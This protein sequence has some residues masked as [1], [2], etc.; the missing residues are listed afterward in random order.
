M[1]EWDW[2][3]TG[4]MPPPN[5]KVG[6]NTGGWSAAVTN[7]YFTVKDSHNVDQSAMLLNVKIDSR[8]RI[9]KAS[10]SSIYSLW[11]VTGEQIESIEKTYRTFP[12]A[13]LESNGTPTVTTYGCVFETLPTPMPTPEP[14]E[15]PY[16]TGGP[17]YPDHPSDAN[18]DMPGVGGYGI[19]LLD[20][21]TAHVISGLCARSDLTLDALKIHGPQDAY[22]IAAL[23]VDLR[24][25][26]PIEPTPVPVDP[27]EETGLPPVMPPENLP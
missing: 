20:Y 24:N 6:S 10:D 11:K 12:V 15:P 26:L 23:M 25:R 9:Q 17:A 5:G 27:P 2:R 3:T 21:F 13:Y 8:I 19:S 14:P 18:A 1:S 16:I 22:W 7:L 4:T